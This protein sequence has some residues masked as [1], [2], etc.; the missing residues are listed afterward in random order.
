MPARAQPTRPPD[1][2]GRLRDSSGADPISLAE[3]LEVVR[4]RWAV[5]L[6]SLLLGGGA[7]VALSLAHHGEYS[8]S[9]ELLFRDPGFDQKLF[10][11][12]TFVPDTD[13]SRVAATNI[14]L[15]SLPVVSPRPAATLH[16]PLALVSSEV[17]ISGV[18]Q[19][20]IA[21]I[22]ATDPSSARAAALANE[23]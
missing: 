6:L 3:L 5:I 10:G 14:D 1:L 19:A 4:R 15:A 9:S 23:Y 17:S 11:A 18:G 2:G 21:K 20:D 7:A 8:A 13:P 16:L 12:S 22:T